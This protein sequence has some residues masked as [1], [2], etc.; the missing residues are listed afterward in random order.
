MHIRITFF[1]CA[2]I[3]MFIQMMFPNMITCLDRTFIEEQNN[4]NFKT[5]NS[6]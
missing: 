6:V 3:N 1:L 2:I 5:K 4:M